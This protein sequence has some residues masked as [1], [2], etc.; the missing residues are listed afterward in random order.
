MELFA[1]CL[2]KLTMVGGFAFGCYA[3]WCLVFDPDREIEQR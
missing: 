3:A 1:I 2:I